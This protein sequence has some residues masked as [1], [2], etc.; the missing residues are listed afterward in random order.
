VLLLFVKEG[1][2]LR[3]FKREVAAVAVLP[4]D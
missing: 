4:D 3:F 1:K 2:A